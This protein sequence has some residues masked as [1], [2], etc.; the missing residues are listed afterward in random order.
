MEELKYRRVLLKLSGEGVMGK[1]SDVLK[2]II[3]EIR[4]LQGEG[5]ELAITLGGGN[6]IRGATAPIDDKPIAHQMG[7]LAT[8]INGLAFKVALTEA[9]VKSQLM[10]ALFMP[11]IAKPFTINKGRSA[12][13]AKDV[14]ILV[15]G[16]GRPFLTSDT[17]TAIKAG[18]LNCDVVVKM[19]QV[20]GIYTEDPRKNE[21]ALKI[22]EIT[23]DAVMEKR[24]GFMDMAAISILK[25]VDVPVI[26]CKTTEPL[27]NI[28]QGGGTYSIV[29]AA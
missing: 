11:E 20:D 19:T 9:G 28:L 17:G 3:S 27:K 2:K 15:G 7:M 24:L 25:D 23:Y 14:V 4:E 16:T 13:K 22:N 21:N 6:L 29:R 10:S 26:V 8:V 1:D 5:V 18:E 12:L